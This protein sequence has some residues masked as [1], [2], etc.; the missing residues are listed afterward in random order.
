MIVAVFVLVVCVLAL[1]LVSAWPPFWSC[2]RMVLAY[3][4]DA[5]ARD[6]AFSDG[7]RAGKSDKWSIEQEGER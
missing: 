3:R 2:V 6:A 5:R 7:Y 1:Q 4:L